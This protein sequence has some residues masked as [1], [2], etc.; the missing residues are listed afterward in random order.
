M[1]CG[2]SVGYDHAPWPKKFHELGHVLFFAG[3]K[4]FSRRQRGLDSA[5]FHAF[6]NLGVW[7]NSG[8]GDEMECD[9]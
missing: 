6:R 2:Y 7:W 1:Q 4:V 9:R 8:S 5:C 3:D